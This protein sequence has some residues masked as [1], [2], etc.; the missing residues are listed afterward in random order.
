MQYIKASL[1]FMNLTLYQ[2]MIQIIYFI[3]KK[4][5]RKDAH[6]NRSKFAL[7]SLKNK[8]KRKMFILIN[9]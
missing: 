8:F 7:T 2:F 6:D 3:R 1:G 5:L 4:A 9:I